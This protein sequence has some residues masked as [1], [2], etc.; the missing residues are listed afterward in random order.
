M[1]NSLMISKMLIIDNVS[2]ISPK[3]EGVRS[4]ASVMLIKRFK[5][6]NEMLVESVHKI[7]SKVFLLKD[8]FSSNVVN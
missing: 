1:P 2:D 6:L 3:S 8:I 5:I 4:L 7:P